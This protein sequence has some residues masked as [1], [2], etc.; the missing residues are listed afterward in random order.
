MTCGSPKRCAAATSAGM[1]W[2]AVTIGR[3]R[4]LY[5]NWMQTFATQMAS[6]TTS[7]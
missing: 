1:A 7:A 2:Y 5:S 6:Q 4:G 3:T